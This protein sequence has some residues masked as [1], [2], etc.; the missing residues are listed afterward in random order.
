MIAI[1]HLPTLLPRESS[2]FFGKDLQD[3]LVALQ[4][5]EKGRV[6]NDAE[7]LFWKKVGESG[8]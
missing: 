6:W 7:T 3:S 8:K 1:D 2:E 4:S 5:Y